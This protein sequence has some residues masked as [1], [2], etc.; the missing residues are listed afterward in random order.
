MAAE[1]KV[2]QPSQ[3]VTLIHSRPKLL[4]SEPLPEDF[5]DRTLQAV[6][7]AGV[8]TIMSQRVM[9]ITSNSANGSNSFDVTLSSGLHIKAGI[10]ISAISKSIPTTQYLPREALDKDGYVRI[11]SRLV[12]SLHTFVYPTYS[13]PPSLQFNPETEV[14][15]ASSHFALGDIAAWSG[16]K[17]CGAALHMGH[18]AAVNIHQLLLQEYHS[19]KSSNYS[20]HPEQASETSFKVSQSSSPFKPKFMEW[21]EIAPTIAIAIGEQAAMWRKEDGTKCGKEEMK[22]MFQNDLG[23]NSKTFILLI[24]LPM[25]ILVNITDLRIVCWEFLRLDEVLA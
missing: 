8:E 20:D 17:R 10:V 7:E 22:V 6:H 15:N 13:C 16:I 11:T 5:K 9:D 2:V 18:V 4:S 21:P 24:W 19:S 3:K 25:I 1:I 23:W 12:P 14:T